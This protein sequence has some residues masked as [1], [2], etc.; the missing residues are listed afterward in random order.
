MK[1]ALRMLLGGMSRMDH[2]GGFLPLQGG[3]LSKGSEQALPIFFSFFFYFSGIPKQIC[4]EKTKTHFSHFS[5]IP[6]IP[7]NMTN[8]EMKHK[9]SDK[10]SFLFL[11]R[12]MRKKSVFNAASTS[13]NALVLGDSQLW[14]TVNGYFSYS[15]AKQPY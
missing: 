9:V 2:F 4:Y 6:A 14:V 3:I 15:S 12:S 10:K 13:T 8:L 11:I 1:N 7:L 5:P